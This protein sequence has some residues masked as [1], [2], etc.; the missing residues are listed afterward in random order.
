M[1]ALTPFSTAPPHL[2]RYT[3]LPMGILQVTGV[4]RID[5]GVYRCM[6]SNIANTRFSHE[7]VLNVTGEWY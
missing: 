6:A 7:A 1:W 3:L 4:R 5:A 2:S